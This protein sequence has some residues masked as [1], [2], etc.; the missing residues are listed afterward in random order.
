M[1]TFCPFQWGFVSCLQLCARP[2]GE[3]LAEQ[4]VV[5][6]VQLRDLA[7][8]RHPAQQVPHQDDV[9]KSGQLGRRNPEWTQL[10]R[11]GDIQGKTLNQI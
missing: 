8:G 9:Q 1:L 10:S 5:E 11:R 2:G 6:L 4:Q 3:G 7:G